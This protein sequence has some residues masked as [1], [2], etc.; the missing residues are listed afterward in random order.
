[1]HLFGVC[2]RIFKA[3]FSFALGLGGVFINNKETIFQ[4]KKGGESRNYATTFTILEKYTFTILEKL[5]F[6]EVI[7]LMQ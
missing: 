7:L 3:C 2:F 5:N 4:K 1:M 6:N